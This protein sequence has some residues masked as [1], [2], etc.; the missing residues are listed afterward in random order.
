MT[1]SQS[2]VCATAHTASSTPLKTFSSWSR[3]YASRTVKRLI[4]D[5]LANVVLKL[6]GGPVT[7]LARLAARLGANMI[8][9]HGSLRHAALS[10]R[11]RAHQ[12]LIRFAG[13]DTMPRM[14]CRSRLLR[15]SSCLV[16]IATL[17]VLSG[18]AG[19]SRG[20]ASRSG[21]PAGSGD[22]TAVSA[23]P[24]TTGFAP[25][26]IEERRALASSLHAAIDIERMRASVRH[27]AGISREPDAPSATG[28]AAWVRD[29]LI[30]AGWTAELVTARVTRPRST[31]RRGPRGR[32]QE[33][34]ARRGRATGGRSVTSVVARLAGSD[35]EGHEIVVGA[36]LVDRATDGDEATA[37]DEAGTGVAA[38]LEVARGLGKLVETGWQ[39]RRTIV[40][41]FWDG[42]VPGRAAARTWLGARAR[43]TATAPLVYLDAGPS[44]LAGPGLEIGTVATLRRL[45][46]ALVA[47]RDT[48][49][50]QVADVVVTEPTGA[51][52]S[53]AF[54][55]A[56]VPVLEI[57]RQTQVPATSQPTSADDGLD[58][59]LAADSAPAGDD[60]DPPLGADTALAGPRLGARLL[61]SA[62][63]RLCDAPLPVSDHS[64]QVLRLLR[65]LN[66]MT[67]AA[68]AAFDDNPPPV[69]STRLA[70]S[71]YR[72]AAEN[73]EAGRDRWL[74]W[75]GS[76]PREADLAAGRQRAAYGRRGR[77][78]AEADE[79]RHRL[80]GAAD[81]VVSTDRVFHDLA[82]RTDLLECG[83]LLYCLEAGQNR[84]GDL[85]FRLRTAIESGE[86]SAMVNELLRLAMAA[87]QAAARLRVAE[88]ALNAPVNEQQ[89]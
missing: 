46:R 71:D 30:D 67:A 20:P 87:R 26:D 8:R 2:T 65:A 82:E 49:G 48:D 69:R 45:A 24:D 56:A 59:P 77:R 33:A 34:G 89:P 42:S 39:P 29:R 80:R 7:P 50:E 66:S 19:T 12:A 5:G 51:A 60:L 35:F 31:A 10:T 76:V 6:T 43:G 13:T 44:L 68:N 22:D 53:G 32:S 86:R 28:A 40:L 52:D 4:V 55:D 38:L 16:A 47:E 79:L 57:H 88:H 72:L 74:T 11:R 25:D 83:S 3:L 36:R 54:L 73:W 15:R 61:G 70:L 41:A 63:L 78:L 84:A 75:V 23:E 1:P 18:C 64:V 27:L 37:A 81:A 21:P 62:V 85:L 17:A 58:P 14:P 9:T